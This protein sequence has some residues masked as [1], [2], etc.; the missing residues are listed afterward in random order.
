MDTEVRWELRPRR[1]FTG[2]PT[3]HAHPDDHGGSFVFRDGALGWW[4]SFPTDCDDESSA[5]TF[6]LRPGQEAWAV[7]GWH[8][9]PEAWSVT[10]AARVL[11]DATTHWREWSDGLK[12]EH[13]DDRAPAL[14]RCALTV[15]LLSH[16]AHDLRCRPR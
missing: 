13:A 7:V 5:R 1:D 8:V 14:R 3:K 9:S 16:V 15:Q 10:Q 4:T 12:L 6:H 11:A 2:C